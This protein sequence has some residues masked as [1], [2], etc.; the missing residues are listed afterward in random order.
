MGDSWHIDYFELKQLK[1]QPVKEGSSGPSSVPT[2]TRRE[3]GTLITRDR[4]FR[5]GEPV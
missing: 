3:R 1:D 5:A 2:E 4:E